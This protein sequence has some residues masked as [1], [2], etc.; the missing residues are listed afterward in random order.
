MLVDVVCE[1]RYWYPDD[2]GEVWV[3]GYHLVD[4][5]RRFLSREAA[6]ERGLHVLS[7]AGAAAHHDR[8]LQGP[9]AV[10]GAPL[11][12]RRDPATEST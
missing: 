2:G 12:L 11:T 7:V 5:D 10:P 1:E 6:G 8:V 9:G 4:A 3:A